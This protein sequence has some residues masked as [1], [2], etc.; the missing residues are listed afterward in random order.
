MQTII[1]SLIIFAAVLYVAQRWLPYAAK[2]RLLQLLGKSPKVKIE[3]SGG[4]CGSC[5]SCGNCGS[6]TVKM[7]K[8]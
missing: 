6:N 8:K 7:I 2:Q 5:S 3:P 1:C 4:A